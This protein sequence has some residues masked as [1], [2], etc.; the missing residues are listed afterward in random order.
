MAI[1]WFTLIAQI[2]NFLILVWLLKFFLLDRIVQAMDEREAKIAQR[3]EGASEAR[4]EAEAEASRFRAKNREF[5]AQRD[6][7][8][9]EV[10]EESEALRERLMAETRQE[11]EAEQ[12]QWLDT[13]KRERL[14]LLE[15]LRERLSHR[16]F[17]SARHALKE[18]ANR[19]LEEQIL[20]GF[21]DRLQAQGPLEREDIAAAIQESGLEVE[22]RTAFPLPSEARE[23]FI[24]DLRQELGEGL[25]VRFAVAPELICGVELWADSQRLFWNL[26]SYLE[27]LE[28]QVLEV[29]DER[30]KNHAQLQQ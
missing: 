7:K 9:A 2:I 8:L 27:D 19:D 6:Q 24:Q 5:D 10:T 21:L 1:D 26:D 16:V 11:L 18:L 22:I 12:S 28:A 14:G 20:R 25:G 17:E 4:A 29:L 3:L 23:G 13:L 30:A 15:D